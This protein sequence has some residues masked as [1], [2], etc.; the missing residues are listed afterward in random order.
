MAGYSAFLLTVPKTAQEWSLWSFHHKL[1][2]DAIRQAL[3]VQGKLTFDFV[4]DPIDFNDITGF[5]QRNSELHIEETGA[6]GLQSHDLQDV[7]F[8]D[9][10]QLVSWIA[11]HHRE[12]FD[13]ELALGI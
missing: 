5:L 6:I 12:H 10:N 7:D 8:K 2:H 11:V 3:T 9:E 13:L 4:I 1:S